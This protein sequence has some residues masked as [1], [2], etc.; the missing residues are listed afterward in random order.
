MLFV[1]FK[2]QGKTNFPVF[3][4][5]DWD[6]KLSKWIKFQYSFLFLDISS[7]VKIDAHKK[8]KSRVQPKPE[9]VKLR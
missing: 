5:I 3:E 1:T 9:N 4:N 8:L 6:Y 7:T 2:T